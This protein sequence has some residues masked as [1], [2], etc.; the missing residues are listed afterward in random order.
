MVN[1]AVDSPNLGEAV[2]AA[3]SFLERNAAGFWGWLKI[4]WVERPILLAAA[5]LFFLV[6]LWLWSRGRSTE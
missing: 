2:R 1:Q 4:Q 6:A 3:G 5:A